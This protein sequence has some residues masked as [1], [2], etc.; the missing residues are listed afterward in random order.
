MRLL[1]VAKH[2]NEGKEL[3]WTEEHATVGEYFALEAE[4]DFPKSRYRWKRSSG[5]LGADKLL[6]RRRSSLSVHSSLV[7]LQ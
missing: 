3:I 2:F 4:L 1:F 6:R 7:E 5:V